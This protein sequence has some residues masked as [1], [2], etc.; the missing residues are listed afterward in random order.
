MYII[1][2][3]THK[4]ARKGGGVGRAMSPAN[5]NNLKFL[6]LYDLLLRFVGHHKIIILD[7]S[8]FKMVN[9]L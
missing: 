4:G 5:N 8:D 1:T 2:Y 9:M 3:P 6:I 7:N